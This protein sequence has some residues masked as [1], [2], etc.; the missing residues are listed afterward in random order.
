MHFKKTACALLLAVASLSCGACQKKEKIDPTIEDT[1]NLYITILNRGYGTD[2]LFAI[3]EAFEKE[4]GINTEVTRTDNVAKPSNDMNKGPNSDMDTDLFFDLSG[5]QGIKSQYTGRWSDYPDGILDMTELYDMKVYGEDITF[6]EKMVDSVRKYENLG[7]EDEPSYW[8]VPWATGFMGMTYNVDVFKLL[9][10]ENYEEKMPN[11]TDELYD[12]AVD[13]KSKGG[14]AFAFPGQIEYFSNAMFAGWWAQYEGVENYENFYRTRAYDESLDA[15]VEG[16]KEIFRQQGRLEALEVM[17][18]LLDTDAGLFNYDRCYAVGNNDFRDLQEQYMITSNKIAMFPN[19]DWLESESGHEGASE[20]GMMKSPVISSIVEVLPD[21]SIPTDDPEEADRILSAVVDYVDAGLPAEKPAEIA[22]VTDND[23]AR[24]AEAR[25][26]MSAMPL[27]H[28]AYAP[29]YT[30]AR[31]NVFKFLTFMASD[32]ALMIYKENVIGG[33]LPFKYDYSG[34]EL[35]K[36]ESDIVGLLN[37]FI[38]CGDDL[39]L[40]APFYRGGLSGHHL[41][42]GTAIETILAA[43]PD[44]EMHMDA[45][46]LWEAFFYTDA[47][48]ELVPGVK[49]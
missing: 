40:S 46:E 43:K 15:Y 25:K 6:G 5:V 44:S 30:N 1:E 3:A 8:A 28:L 11:T 42:D 39:R 27:S 9:Y 14:E 26:C 48:W 36:F 45:E 34:A 13:I 2:W 38:Y 16:S 7:T 4:T 32:E 22:N 24:I 20:I 23:I 10:G 49:N 19:G 31:T 37:D 18:K 29:A 35:T 21:K 41:S 33:F 47:E 17:D 12:L